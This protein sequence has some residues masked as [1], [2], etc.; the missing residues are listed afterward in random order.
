VEFDVGTTGRIAAGQF[1]YFG[2]YIDP[3]GFSC[4]PTLSAASS[5]SKP[6]PQPRSTTVSPGR[7]VAIAVGL[8]HESPM[9]ASGGIDANS[10]GE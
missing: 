6:P 9:L 5:T 8:P 10:S 1:Q 2:R 7:N 3:D 4:G